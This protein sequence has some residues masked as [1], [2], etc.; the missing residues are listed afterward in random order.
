MRQPQADPRSRSGRTRRDFLALGAAT[1]AG[2]L[3]SAC[4]SSGSSGSS[5]SAD[6]TATLPWLT[7]G[8]HYVPGELQTVAR[9][10]GVTAKPTLIGDNAPTY[11]K[12]KQTDGQFAVVSGD[13]LWLP[14]YYADGLTTAIDLSAIPVASQLYAA[15]REA[16]ILQA[17]GGA[18][19]FPFA[20]STKPVF[21][22]PKHVTVK[23]D[24]WEALLSPEYEKKIVL[25]GDTTGVMT[26]GGLAIG[27]ERPFNMTE[28]EIADAKEYLAKLK[29]NIL[30]FVSQANE[31]TRAMSNES[32]WIGVANLGLDMQVKEAS[33]VEIEHVI[34][35]E[36]TYGFVDAEQSIRA[37]DSL[38]AFE[39]WIDQAYRAQ[40][41]ARNFLEYGRPLFNEAAF[42]LLVDQ[43]HGEQAERLLYD[44]PE[45]AFEQTLVG[46]ADNQQ[47]YTDAFNEIFG[48]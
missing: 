38:D 23:P 39:R 32:A 6:G 13:A 46:P 21:Y 20:W 17:D 37:S 24:S 40:W 26:I 7:W 28:S 15:A 45:L 43:G 19:G 10:T 48:S 35:R 1:G 27:A 33:G 4:G 22:N 31:V 2:V 3:L 9:R 11:L 12:V 44:R 16:P 25:E 41:C 14:K 30:K 47:A 42:R 29:P 18:Y 8:D 34:P 5:T 36:G